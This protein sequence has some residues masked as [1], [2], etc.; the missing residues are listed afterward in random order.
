MTTTK[1]RVTTADA[2]DFLLAFEHEKRDAPTVGEIAT[3]LGVSVPAVTA[4]A[5]REWRDHGWSRIMPADVYRSVE[6]VKGYG[7]LCGTSE[8]KRR[9]YRVARS[10]LIARALGDTSS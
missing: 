3:G 9:G 10:W 6:R 8:R 1:A 4:W 5:K 2:L 7:N